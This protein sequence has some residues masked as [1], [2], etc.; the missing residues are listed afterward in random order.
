MGAAV[1]LAPNQLRSTKQTNVGAE[2]GGGV[3]AVFITCR[4]YDNDC[5]TILCL[6]RSA[7]RTLAPAGV[8]T[9]TLPLPAKPSACGH[10]PLAAGALTECNSAGA[11]FLLHMVQRGIVIVELE[12]HGGEVEETD[13]GRSS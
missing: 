9:N 10:A 2:G 12:H 3:G 8:R 5:T 13:G 6:G 7:R 4:V 1:D 11:A